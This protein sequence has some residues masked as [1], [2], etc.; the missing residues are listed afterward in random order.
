MRRAVFLD[1]GGFDEKYAPA[2]CED[3][4]LSF[5]LRRRGLKTFYQPRSEVIHFEG[6]SHGRDVRTGVKA[7][8]VTNQA[9][10]LRTWYDV[11]SRSHFRNGTHVPRAKDRA[12]GRKIVLIVDHYVQNRIATRAR[13]P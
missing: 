8:Q 7:C 12:H 9:T 13:A 2:Y 5:R 6:A 4:D 11:L 1:A 10:F 3:S